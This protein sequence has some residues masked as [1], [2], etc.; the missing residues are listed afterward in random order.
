MSRQGNEQTGSSSHSSRTP[1]CQEVAIKSAEAGVTAAM[2][3][4]R[5]AGKTAFNGCMRQ[6]ALQP[7]PNAT[8]NRSCTT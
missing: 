2:P 5:L 7:L 8:S 4:V 1:M 3:Q 6:H